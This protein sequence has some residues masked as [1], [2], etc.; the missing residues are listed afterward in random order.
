M[1]V[2]PPVLLLVQEHVP[3][4]PRE[5]ARSPSRSDVTVP[6]RMEFPDPQTTYGEGNRQGTEEEDI[7]T[8]TG[9]CLEGYGRLPQ[10]VSP[11]LSAP[12]IHGRDR[13]PPPEGR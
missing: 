13:V 7:S 2:G 9:R 12:E 5:S 8:L 1:P 10:Y 6:A 4:Y 3:S 11:R